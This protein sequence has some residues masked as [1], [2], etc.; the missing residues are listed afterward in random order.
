MFWL[1]GRTEARYHK[2]RN[3]RRRTKSMPCPSNSPKHEAHSILSPAA[4]PPQ[5]R[6]PSRLSN[7]NQS[8]SGDRL[9]DQRGLFNRCNLPPVG[10]KERREKLSLAHDEHF[11]FD[12]HG[13][14]H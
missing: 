13:P 6:L 1:T 10:L 3:L 2:N 11:L 12:V 14:G 5:Q 9:E 4:F 8:A 7:L